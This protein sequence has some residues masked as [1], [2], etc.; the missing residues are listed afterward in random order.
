MSS[1]IYL[2]IPVMLVLAILQATILP[3]FPILGLVPQLP[4]LVALSWGFLRGM[5]EGG[6]WAFTAGICLDLFS[7]G[8]MGATALAYMLAVVAVIGLSRAL[9]P[10]RSFIPAILTVL[11]TLLSLLLYLVML[12]L[13]GYRF[14][15]AAHSDILP[16]ALLH[17]ALILPLFWLMRAAQRRIQPRPVEL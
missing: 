14:D 13:I 17:G 12:W 7:A 6:I 1:N 10:N 11:A 15:L 4:F 3:R 8:P 5:N 2:A 16:T 9:P